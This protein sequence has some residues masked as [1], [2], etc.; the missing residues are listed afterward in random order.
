MGV[1]FVSLRPFTMTGFRKALTR[2][3]GRKNPELLELSGEEDHI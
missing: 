1:M 2:W 3:K